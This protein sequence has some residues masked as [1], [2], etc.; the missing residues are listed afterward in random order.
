MTVFIF[1]LKPNTLANL[2]Y[3]RCAVDI[4]LEIYQHISSHFQNVILAEDQRA[5][6]EVSRQDFNVHWTLNLLKES[7]AED[8]DAGFEIKTSVISIVRQAFRWHPKY[9]QGFTLATLSDVH[10][11]ILLAIVTQT[12]TDLLIALLPQAQSL[13]LEQ[14]RRCLALIKDSLQNISTVLNKYLD[15][16]GSNVPFD[17]RLN[18]CSTKL[19]VE[20]H[21]QIDEIRIL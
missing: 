7:T 3:Y 20:L 2:P 16:N 17:R 9:R 8:A 14:K 4:C 5:Q 1:E 21:N 19:K 10:P 11:K 18:L 15:E 12:L 13:A 6:L